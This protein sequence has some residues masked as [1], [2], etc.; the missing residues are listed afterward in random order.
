ML[1]ESIAVVRWLVD[2]KRLLMVAR[3]AHVL[4]HDAV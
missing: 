4:A 2:F 1:L 3:T